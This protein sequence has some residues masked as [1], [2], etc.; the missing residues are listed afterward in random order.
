MK[1]VLNITF[2]YS[3][4]SSMSS[5]AG[6]LG[7]GSTGTGGSAAVAIGG[8]NAD[9]LMSAEALAVTPWSQLWVG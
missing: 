7:G 6:S 4:F 1:Y 8:Q 2:L 9:A 5:D 3:L